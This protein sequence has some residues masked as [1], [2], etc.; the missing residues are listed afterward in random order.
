MA[1]ITLLYSTPKVAPAL[2]DSTSLSNSYEAFLVLSLLFKCVFKGF[3]SFGSR[4][5]IGKTKE[6][7]GILSYRFPFRLS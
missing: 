2:R 1:D 5:P 7:I 3:L 6:S 4:E